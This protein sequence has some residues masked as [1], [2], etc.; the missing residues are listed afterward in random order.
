M[1]ELQAYSEDFVRTLFFNLQTE[2]HEL[3]LFLISLLTGE[4]SRAVKAC[5]KDWGDAIQ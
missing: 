5:Q 2:K 1:Q 4:P 3:K